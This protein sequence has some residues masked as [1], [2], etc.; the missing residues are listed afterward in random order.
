MDAG[1]RVVRGNIAKVY[2]L[3]PPQNYVDTLARKCKGCLA[4]VYRPIETDGG[5]VR[6]TPIPES[7]DNGLLLQ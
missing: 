2:P 6:K 5:Q 4:K 1:C 3:A 7:K